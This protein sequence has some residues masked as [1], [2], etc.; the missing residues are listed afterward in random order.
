MAMDR[1][2]ATASGEA[3]QA[4]IRSRLPVPGAKSITALARKAGLRPNTL[5]SWWTEGRRPD[6]ASLQRVAIA[7]GVDLSEL[8]AAYEGSSGRT[9]VFTDPELEALID[10]VSEVTVRRVLAEQ[11]AVPDE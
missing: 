5:S 3:L 8:V 7:L 2:D 4:F 1:Y 11:K 9:W 10:R 6:S